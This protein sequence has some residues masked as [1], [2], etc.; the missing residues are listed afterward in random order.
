MKKTVSL[1]ILILFLSLFAIA[2]SSTKTCPAYGNHPT[3]QTDPQ[4]V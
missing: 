2:C 1:S 3:E 4:N